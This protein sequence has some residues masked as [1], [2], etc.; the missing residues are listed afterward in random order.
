MVVR[1]RATRGHT[2][3]RRSHHWLLGPRL[4][5]CK[6]CGGAH[7]RHRACATCGKY[8]GHVVIDIA[9][10]DAKRQRRQKEKQ[11]VAK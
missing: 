4:S 7:V 10:K 1:M 9:A 3:N 2:A 5:T 8:R 6:D 11:A